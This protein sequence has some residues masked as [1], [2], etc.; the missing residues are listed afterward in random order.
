MLLGLYG[1]DFDHSIILLCLI[2]SSL[3]MHAAEAILLGYA[4]AFFDAAYL[5]R[6]AMTV[7]FAGLLGNISAPILG[8]LLVAT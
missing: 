1:Y 2:L 8:A 7:A 4:V 5:S 3:E 6:S